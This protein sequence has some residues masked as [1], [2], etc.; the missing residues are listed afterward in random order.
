MGIW[1]VLGSL[2][3]VIGGLA[4]LVDSEDR[5]LANL[6]SRDVALQCTSDMATQFHIHA[7]LEIDISGVRREIPADVGINPSCMNSLH[8]HDASGQIHIEAPQKRDFTLGDF[9][10]VWKQ[11]FS[12]NRILDAETDDA[13]VIRMTVNG[14][15]FDTYENTV[16]HDD[17]QIVISYEVKK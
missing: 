6:S 4:A 12:K 14:A 5:R 16:L 3:V 2:V 11:P 8:T 7:N 9:F 10:A 1:W 17:D 15:P 13:H